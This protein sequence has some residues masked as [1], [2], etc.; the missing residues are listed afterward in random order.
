MV[1]QLYT[2]LGAVPAAAVPETWSF[3]LDGAS[4]VEGPFAVTQERLRAL[5]AFKFYVVCHGEN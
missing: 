3:L 1:L 5:F 2:D 4:H